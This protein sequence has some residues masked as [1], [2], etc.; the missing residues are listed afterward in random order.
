MPMQK[1][2]IVEDD[3]SLQ[4]SL[5][6]SLTSAGFQV[7]AASDGEEGLAKS[8]EHPDLIIL[9]IMLPKMNGL[10]LMKAIRSSPGGDTIPIIILTNHDTTDSTIPAV[11]EGHP[12]YYLLKSSI[13]LQSLTNKVKS[14]LGLSVETTV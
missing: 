1:I 8:S 10:E 12:A 2:L 14:A 4:D 3:L 11:L 6:A 7:I 9:D 5:V 13:D